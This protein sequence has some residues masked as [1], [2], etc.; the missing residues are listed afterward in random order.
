MSMISVQVDHHLWNWFVASAR[1][2]QVEP[3]ILLADLLREYLETEEDKVL[4][5]EMRRDLQG[6]ELSNRQAVSFVHKQRRK[7]TT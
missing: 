3:Q 7:R 6:Q 4:D 5:D 1:Q 2:R